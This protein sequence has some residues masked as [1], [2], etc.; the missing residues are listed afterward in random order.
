MLLGEVDDA[1]LGGRTDNSIPQYLDVTDRATAAKLAVKVDVTHRYKRIYTHASN[2]TFI[3]DLVRDI[4]HILSVRPDNILLNIGSNDLAALFDDFTEA[5]VIAIAHQL[6][7]F[8]QFSVPNHIIVVCMGVVPRLQGINS[9]PANFREA[10]RIF[11]TEMQL[12]EDQARNMHEPSNLRFNK[13]RGWD[14]VQVNNQHIELDPRSWCNNAGIHPRDDVY[15]TKFKESVKR[16]LTMS[17]NRPIY[18]N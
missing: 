7:D 14:F 3:A 2:I 10:A 6:R 11:N 8:I 15:T 12:L 13:M 4:D 16:A 9:T 18:I 5:Q 1:V 17:K